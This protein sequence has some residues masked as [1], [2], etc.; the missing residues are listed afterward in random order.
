MICT[1]TGWAQAQQASCTKSCV[2]QFLCENGTQL[3]MSLVF[4]V[5]LFLVKDNVP[6]RNLINLIFQ[7]C[8]NL[9]SILHLSDNVDLCACMKD[10]RSQ[11]QITRTPWSYFFTVCFGIPLVANFV[12]HCNVLSQPRFWTS[13]GHRLLSGGGEGERHLHS[14][15]PYL[16]HPMRRWRRKTPAQ[17]V[18]MSETAN[19]W[20]SQLYDNTIGSFRKL[21]TYT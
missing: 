11:E 10:P 16:K 4:R 2:Q 20:R 9:C 5:D 12:R 14:G 21:E 13:I 3:Y 1:G 6:G 7:E 18:T 15:S 8:F 17:W 19:E